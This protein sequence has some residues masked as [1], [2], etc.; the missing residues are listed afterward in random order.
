MGCPRRSLF[1]TIGAEHKP[2]LIRYS[3]LPATNP[4]K[5]ERPEDYGENCF[6]FYDQIYSSV[7]R[8][9]IPTLHRLTNNGSVLELGIG[10]GRIALLLAALGVDVHGVDASPSMLA[11]LAEKPGAAQLK[12]RLA[13]FAEEVSEGPFSL[14]FALVST[15]Y[16]LRSSEEQQRSLHTLVAELSADGLLLLENYEP[17]GLASL[18]SSGESADVVYIFKQLIATRNGLRNYQTRICY[19]AP[20]ELDKMAASAG[21]RLRERWSGWQG[22]TFQPGDRCHISIYEVAR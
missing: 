13:N 2:N 6:D 17:S 3:T 5:P 9:V 10:T 21:L 20:S 18:T 8:N 15:F 22:Q 7:P 19:A 14:I 16:L 11:K 1:S 4:I 12:V